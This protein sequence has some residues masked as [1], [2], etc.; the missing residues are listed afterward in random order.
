MLNMTKHIIEKQIMTKIFFRISVLY[1]FVCGVL[2][3]SI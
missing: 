3:K 1:I 2:G